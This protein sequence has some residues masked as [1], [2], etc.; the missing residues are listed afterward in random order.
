MFSCGEANISSREKL[1]SKIIFKQNCPK[2][3]GSICSL[4][5]KLGQIWPLRLFG[6]HSGL[7]T[8]F[9]LLVSDLWQFNL[10]FAMNQFLQKSSRISP[11]ILKKDKKIKFSISLMCAATLLGPNLVSMYFNVSYFR[12]KKTTWGWKIGISSALLAASLVT[13]GISFAEFFRFLIALHFKD[14]HCNLRI[15]LLI[16]LTHFRRITDIE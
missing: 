13:F 4:G 8:S 7:K 10:L 9:S 2:K 14:K 1:P 3:H 6:G 11:K 15:P 5:H 12:E 16:K